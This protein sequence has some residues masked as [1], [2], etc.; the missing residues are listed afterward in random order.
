[1]AKEYSRSGQAASYRGSSFTRGAEELLLTDKRSYSNTEKY[2]R[3]RYVWHFDD[4]EG[5]SNRNVVSFI[6]ELEHNRRW[7]ASINTASRITVENMQSSRQPVINKHM[8][9]LKAAT[10]RGPRG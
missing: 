5:R 9:E 8:H 2:C 7:L 3:Q 6:K 4:N 1:L 10:T